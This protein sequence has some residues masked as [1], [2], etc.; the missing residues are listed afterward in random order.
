MNTIFFICKKI[1]YL[2]DQYC[3]T[4]FFVRQSSIIVG[5]FFVI[6]CLIASYTFSD[7][8][9]IRENDVHREK[10]EQLQASIERDDL[11]EIEEIAAVEYQ[12][13]IITFSIEVLQKRIAESETENQLISPIGISFLLSM[14][15]HAVGP[16]DQMEIERIIHLPKDE[17]ELKLSAFRLIRKM[18]NNGVDIA[19]LLYLN[20]HYRL[21]PNYQVLASQYYQSKVESGSS[22]K[23]VNDWVQ[24]MTNGQ[25]KKIVDQRDLNNFFVLL[26]NAIHFKADWSVP[27]KRKDTYADNFATPTQVIQTDMM[28]KSGRIEYFEDENCQAIR[29]AYKGNT[30]SLLLLLPKIDNDFSFISELSLASICQGLQPTM[31]KIA[32]PIFNLKQDI[33]LKKMLNE[34]GL[35]HLFGRPDFSPLV[36]L[37]HEASKVAL[38]KLKITQMKQNVVLACDEKGTEA[39]AVTSAIIGATCVGVREEKI[40]EMNFNRPFL[41]VLMTPEVPILFGVIRDPSH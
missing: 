14:I 26:A 1:I 38:P 8:D 18:M 4:P 5:V 34:M 19:G 20:P 28:H 35:I 27:F 40:K 16:E 30:C 29:M 22:A 9:H 32:L 25:I 11:P 7:E 33:D 41:V 15:K 39:S 21:N 2:L 23:W 37:N 31:V 10:I 12:E 36:D 3:F 6:S 17:N 24:Q 13:G